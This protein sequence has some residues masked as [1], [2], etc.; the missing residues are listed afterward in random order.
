MTHAS[1]PPGFPLSP[2]STDLKDPR[3][4]SGRMSLPEMPG[5]NGNFVPPDSRPNGGQLPIESE[6]DRQL[7]AR[8]AAFPMAE[9]NRAAGGIPVELLPVPDMYEEEPPLDPDE[10]DALL[11]ALESPSRPDLLAGHVSGTNVPTRVNPSATTG[12]LTAWKREIKRPVLPSTTAH[13]LRCLL[14]MATEAGRQWSADPQYA[15]TEADI[16]HLAVGQMTQQMLASDKSPATK[17]NYRSAILWACG[18]PEVIKPSEEV[19]RAVALLRAFKKC[20]HVR[21]TQSTR[22]TRSKGRSIPQADLGPLLNALLSGS[23][24]KEWW[25]AK[26]TVWLN[27]AIASG[28]R[29][30]EWE[31]AHWLDEDSG[32]LRLPNL[33]LKKH[34]PFADAWVHAPRRFV[35][36]AIVSLEAM[37][38]QEN[39]E[40]ASAALRRHRELRTGGSTEMRLE[41]QIHYERTLAESAEVTAMDTFIRW[42][43]WELRNDELAWRDIV[44]ERHWHLDVRAHMSQVRTYLAHGGSNTFERYFNNCRRAMQVASRLAFPDGRL[45]SLYD[46]RSTAVANARVGIGARESAAAF[47]HYAGDGRTLNSN[48]ASAAR[49]FRGN[50]TRGPR[51]AETLNQANFEALGEASHQ[52]QRP[53]PEAQAPCDPY[54]YDYDYGGDTPAD[55]SGGSGGS[56]I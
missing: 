28:A 52:A 56:A 49:A 13:Y 10:I 53:N 26:T 8:F 40:A 9:V 25:G 2:D 50:R 37:A 43:A 32:V 23:R 42:R 4:L 6:L 44:I 29:P 35:D 5:L 45:Y 21:S 27:A 19:D 30:G 22:K 39:N 46:A 20:D 14:T 31:A 24:T 33:K 3:D 18:D 34:V 36:Q 17:A 41:R 16:Q 47:G 51:S 48:Y 15:A 12:S 11:R 7:I 54:D 1:G 55:G 38:A